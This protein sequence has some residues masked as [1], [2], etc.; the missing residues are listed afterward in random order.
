MHRSLRLL[1]PRR[2]ALLGC[3]ALLG[4][5]LAALASHAGDLDEPVPL[6]LA[7]AEPAVRELIRAWEAGEKGAGGSLMSYWGP[8]GRP[9]YLVTAPCCDHFNPLYDAEG[10]RICA[11]T[12]G[13]GGAGDG[14]CPGWVHDE[15]R[16]R[17]IRLPGGARAQ[18]PWPPASGG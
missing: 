13:F 11:P 12:G 7:K 8:D 3:L 9:I 15:N 6:S 18:A 4:G 17:K 14:T 10:R 16:W 1:A 5:V 2:L